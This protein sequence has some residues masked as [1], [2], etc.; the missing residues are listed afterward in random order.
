MFGYIMEAWFAASLAIWVCG[1]T[2]LSEV[3]DRIWH[4]LTYFMLPISGLGFMI[5]WLPLKWQRIAEMVPM[6]AALEI[7]R[8]GYF[9]NLVRCH[10]SI[11][12]LTTVNLVLMLTGMILIKIYCRTAEPG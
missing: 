8:D 7:M 5:D 10:Y 4:P 12:Y 1:A 2:E 11:L 3:W 9:G 6:W